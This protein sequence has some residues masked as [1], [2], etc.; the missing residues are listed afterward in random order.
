MASPTWYDLLGVSPDATGEQIK[1][2]W[3]AATDRFEPGSG[4]NQFR[5]FNEGADVLL[6]PVKRAA[7]DREIGLAVPAAAAAPESPVEPAEPVEAGE[8]VEP[9]ASV[10]PGEPAAPAPVRSSGLLTSTLALAVLAVLATASLVLAGFLAVNLQHRADDIAAG[11]EASAVAERALTAAL[12]FDYHDM[13]A[14]RDRAAGFM[15]PGYRKVFLKSF[16]KLEDTA[17]GK[18]GLATREKT[19]VKADVLSTGV[20]TAARGRVQVL[21][22]V[23][24]TRSNVYGSQDLFKNRLVV[25]MVRRGNDWLIDFIKSFGTDYPSTAQQ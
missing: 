6:D 10:E 19:V 4:A 15:T 24:Q 21:A 16:A 3:R 20:V 18:P 17:D 22:F 25:T 13:A 23:N 14:S 2:A 5:L 8:P 7:Y 11:P 1:A 12:S 9:A